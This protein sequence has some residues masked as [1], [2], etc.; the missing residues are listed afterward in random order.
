MKKLLIPLIC[1]LILC[2]ICAIPVKNDLQ[3][4]DKVIRLHVLANSD[5]DEDQALKLTVRDG[6]LE[7]IAELTENCKSKSEA[8]A[9]LREN[10][11]VISENAEKI[12][13]ENGYDYPVSVVIGQEKYP[14]REYE[15]IRFPSGEYCSLRIN[16]GEAEGKNWWCVLFPP[17]CVGSAVEVK[18]EMIS[19]G[20]TPDQVQVLTDSQTPKYR[21]R[22]KI[23]DLIGSL[24]S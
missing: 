14:E 3:I 19:V 21:L 2:F 12:V 6:I 4:Y 11:V 16:I 8:E 20:F 13:R 9:V 10:S 7:S 24:F 5:S 1:V 15:G 22:F 23:L 18:E 17:L